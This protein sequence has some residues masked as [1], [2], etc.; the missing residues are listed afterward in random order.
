M[1]RRLTSQS[2]AFRLRNSRG[3]GLLTM[4]R[5]H[6][7]ATYLFSQPPRT[8]SRHPAAAAEA[9]EGFLN[10]LAGTLFLVGYLFFDGLVSTTQERVFGKNPSSTDPFGPESP[11]LD[12]MV[13][14]KPASRI[15]DTDLSYAHRS[16]RTCS[17]AELLL[18]SRCFPTRPALSFPIFASS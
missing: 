18:S 11:V 16:G 5:S 12:Q 8:S 9:H 13:I 10:G 1:D 6:S 7:C 4:L 17:L 15:A 14:R 2:R 3:I